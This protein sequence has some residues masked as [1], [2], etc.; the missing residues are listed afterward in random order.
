MSNIHTSYI[1][2][3]AVLNAEPEAIV[4]TGCGRE[5]VIKAMP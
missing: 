4:G 3:L 2:S 5:D 1:L